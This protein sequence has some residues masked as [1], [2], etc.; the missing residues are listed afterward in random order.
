MIQKNTKYCIKKLSKINASL[1]LNRSKQTKGQIFRGRHKTHKLLQPNN[2]L[3]KTTKGLSFCS[4]KFR[5]QKVH[6]P[7]HAHSLV[8]HPRSTPGRCS[9]EYG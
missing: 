6:K 8:P 7:Y 3:M 9:S 2:W 1:Y 4:K 5:H